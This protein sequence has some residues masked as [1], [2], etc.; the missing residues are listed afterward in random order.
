MNYILSL[1]E[2]S[3]YRNVVFI[4]NDMVI[5]PI[6]KVKSE[7]YGKCTMYDIEDDP[8]RPTLF[9]VSE[10]KNG[11]VMVNSNIPEEMRRTGIATQFYLNINDLSMV[12]TGK[13]LRSNRGIL[14]R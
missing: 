10:N 3:K 7:K 12:K 13:P 5:K 4:I 8:R 14:F 1:N 9:T 11:W 2:F 6:K